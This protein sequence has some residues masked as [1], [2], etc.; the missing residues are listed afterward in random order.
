MASQVIEM[1]YAAVGAIAGGFQMAEDVLSGVDT[2][3][4]GAYDILMSAG[5]LSFGTTAA[6]AQQVQAMR[7]NLDNTKK[8]CH[9]NQ[10]RLK[11][12]VK[13]HQEGDY[14]AGTYFTDGIEL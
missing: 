5:F 2:A 13:D 12:A 8:L 4:Q 6:L 9:T 1:D 14:Q 7:Q 11:K 3:L 10:V